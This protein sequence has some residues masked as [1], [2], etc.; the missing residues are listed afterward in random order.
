[1]KNIIIK[2]VKFLGMLFFVLAIFSAPALYGLG[3]V[4]WYKNHPIV[5][6]QSTWRALEKEDYANA[7]FI[8]LQ[9]ASNLVKT[10]ALM[11]KSESAIIALLGQPQNHP[12]VAGSAYW[13]APYSLDSMWLQIIYEN[14]I[15]KHIAIVND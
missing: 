1:M 8:R 15:A 7:T 6:E 4:L 12:D 5:F 9:M 10:D 11:N 14:G 2:L 13:L 3:K